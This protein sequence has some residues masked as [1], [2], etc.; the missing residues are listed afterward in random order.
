MGASFSSFGSSTKAGLEIVARGGSGG[1]GFNGGGGGATRTGTNGFKGR[2]GAGA[3]TVS[4]DEIGA[5]KIDGIG[6]VSFGT[7]SE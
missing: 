1:A 7:D 3:K 4:C 5:S 2:F 6:V